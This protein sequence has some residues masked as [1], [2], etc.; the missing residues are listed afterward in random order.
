M[1]PSSE[2]LRK[3]PIVFC[4]LTIYIIIYSHVEL[5]VQCDAHSTYNGIKHKAMI[6][7]NIF[8]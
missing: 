6:N 4:K 1:I 8:V 7:D 3:T 2:N 5:R